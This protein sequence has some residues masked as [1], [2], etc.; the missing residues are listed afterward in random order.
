MRN[1]S[2][3]IVMTRAL[4]LA[5]G[6]RTEDPATLFTED[7]RAWSPN[8]SASS[9]GDLIEAFDDRNEALSNVAVVITGL[10]VVD[11]KGFAEWVV[12]ADHTGPVVLD[13]D[14][15]LPAT[16]R[17]LQLAGATVGEFRD[18]RIRAFRTYFDS[19]ALLE[20]MIGPDGSG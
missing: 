5:V 18:E 1:E 7:V 8:L 4:E 6:I 11:N 19:A 17:R 20:Q 12:E 3:R 9:L 2:R 13:D 14:V 15:L 10:E 16:G